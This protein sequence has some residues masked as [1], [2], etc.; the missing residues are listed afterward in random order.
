MQNERSWMYNKNLPDRGGLTDEFITGLRQFLNF[1]SSNVE[2]M[3][4]N[5][6]R[7]PCRKCHNGKFL[8][9][10]KVSEH[11]CRFGFTPN[12]YNWTCHGEPFISDE[13]CYGHNIQ[14]SRDQS[15]Y[16]Q[17]NPY[18]RMI[19]DAAAPNLIPE[20][21]GASSSC[22]PTVEQMFT[23]Y[24]SPLE[25]VQV[26][27]VDEIVNNETYLK[28][29]EV[30]SAADEPLWTG[31][32]K[33]T[34]LSFTARLL[35]IKAESNLS[36]DNFNKVVQAIEEALPQDNILPNDFY[37]MKKL[38]KELG[39]PVERI[40]VC[41]D[42]CMLYWG[43]DADANVCRFCNQDRYKISRRSQQRRKSYSQ[44]FYLPLTPRIFQ[45]LYSD[46]PT[47]E[48][49]RFCDQE[50]APWFK[51]YVIRG[52]TLSLQILAL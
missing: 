36:E 46:M 21:H 33:H 37:S 26:P 23:T 27:G 38:T 40:D 29:Q 45:N 4:G 20:P 8:P 32:D 35:N 9:S 14:V 7:C 2:F 34:K 6:I 28:F 31:C 19:F 11:L 48:F 17:L 44:L 18:Q 22:P 1:A 50:F 3:D 15:Y 39:L 25:E 51:S 43:D 13:D 16:N 5:Q 24:A 30:L 42:G 52:E 47:L 10:N 41:R 12:Y 49:D